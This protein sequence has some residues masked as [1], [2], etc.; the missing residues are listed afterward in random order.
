MKKPAI[1]LGRL[2]ALILVTVFAG[3]VM[4]ATGIKSTPKI[5]FFSGCDFAG[6]RGVISRGAGRL[7]SALS[8]T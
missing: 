5:T 6:K 3:A 1:A 7:T 4:F 2:A 8:A